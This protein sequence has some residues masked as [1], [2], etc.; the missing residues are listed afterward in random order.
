[1]KISYLLTEIQ[2]K[3]NYLMYSPYTHMQILFGFCLL[4]IF[5][6]VLHFYGKFLHFFLGFLMID[7][8]PFL[9]YSIQCSGFGCWFRVFGRFPQACNNLGMFL[10]LAL[11][12]KVLPCV[13][14]F[15]G[16]I[17]FFREFGAK[18]SVL[19]KGFCS[20]SGI[21]QVCRTNILSYKCCA[22]KFLMNSNPPRI[23]RFVERKAL[24]NDDVS[25]ETDDESGEEKECYV[26]DDE[27]D[28]IKLR[29]LIKLERNRANAAVLELEKERMAA[30]SA[31]E[32]L[33]AK[34]L[35]LENE[36]NST[37]IQFNQNRIMAELK[38]QYDDEVIRYLKWVITRLED[39]LEFCGKELESNGKDGCDDLLIS[40]LES[41]SLPPL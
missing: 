19:K 37:E 5:G 12:F 23:D 38:Q 4:L 28:V 20:R 24:V 34:I 21:D 30:A 39:Q 35:C 31:V 7:C 29:K 9:R 27:I 15:K 3:L 11:G 18:S 17:Q 41:Q 1:M 13:Y 32:E 10:M 2:K 40:S 36:K 22:L 6:S 16:L 26:E 33:M 14:R 8:L 25:E